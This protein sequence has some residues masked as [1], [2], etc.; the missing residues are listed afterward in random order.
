MWPS[1][2]STLWPYI[3]PWSS[4]SRLS[5][6]VPPICCTKRASGQLLEQKTGLSFPGSHRKG[7]S[8]F[9]F[10][11]SAT[12]SIICELIL[13]TTL[14]TRLSTS[15]FWLQMAQQPLDVYYFVL[16]IFRIAR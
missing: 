16:A 7:S 11:P 13:W 5:L 8:S 15:V 10:C 1:K 2:S 9:R 4:G 14:R 3:D 6:S 12:P